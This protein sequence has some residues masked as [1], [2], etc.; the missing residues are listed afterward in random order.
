MIEILYE[1]W[2]S[3]LWIDGYRFIGV[4]I[5]LWLFILSVVIGGVLA[6]FLAIGR[7][8]SNKYI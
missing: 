2:K 3:L 4:A 6:L 8:F 7:V 5:I 1:Y